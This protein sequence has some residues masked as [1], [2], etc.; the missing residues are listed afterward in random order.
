MAK[1]IVFFIRQQHT[2]D[3]KMARIVM[4]FGGTSVGTTDRIKIVA[5][6]VK[7]EVEAGNEVAVVVS[8]MSGA[9][10]QLVDWTREVG[11]LH[12]AR[13]YDVVVSSGEQVTVGL[14][15][16][17]LQNIG[18]DARSWLGWQVA[19]HTDNVHGGAR[20]EHIDAEKMSDRLK[21]GQV[22]V[23]AGFQGV[24]DDNRITTLGRGGSDTS[25]VALAAALEADRCD[26]YTDVD[27]VYTTDPRIVPKATKLDTITF[28][29][30]LELASGGAKVL[31]T[32]SVAMAMRHNVALQ[33]L[34][35]FEDLPG[36]MV[37][38]EEDNMEKNSVSGIA[39]SADEAKITL[40]GLV[41][42]P[43][44]AA[45][46]FSS[47]ADQ[48]VNVDMIVQT[49]ASTEGRTDIT[50]SVSGG[51]VDRA[52]NVL[53]AIKEDID[54]QNLLTSEDVCKISVVGMAMRSQ[55]GIAKTMFATLADKGINIE[56]ISTSEIKI[57]VLISR[58]Y[59]ELAVRSLHTAF[60]LDGE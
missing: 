1:D 58:D 37:V 42:K 50:F 54:Y 40:A 13:E 29:E 32:R 10:N 22:A 45:T 20:I 39:Y 19:M 4:K 55:P 51:D 3:L 34:S 11:A 28:E 43:G 56:V 27:G 49:A 5:E 41:D 60:G 31:Q 52:K 9:T 57:S 8:A 59:T 2:K 24:A 38:R 21:N 36:T 17:A 23:M 46:V 16:I 7:L 35:S 6:K 25:A 18:V 53:E 30:M 47:L 26:I 12:D 15:A 14:L 44:I 48:N 33:V